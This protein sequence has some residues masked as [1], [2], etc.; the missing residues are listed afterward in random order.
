MANL[1]DVAVFAIFIVIL[2]QLARPNSPRTLDVQVWT[3]DVERRM[4][5]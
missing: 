4:M 3:D 5:R 2:L 1:F